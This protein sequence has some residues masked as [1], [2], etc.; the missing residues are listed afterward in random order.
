[1]PQTPGVGVAGAG[2]SAAVDSAHTAVDGGS[3]RRDGPWGAVGDVECAA[4]LQA[5]AADVSASAVG[6]GIDTHRSRIVVEF[7]GYRP[8]YLR[9]LPHR[10]HCNAQRGVGL[11]CLL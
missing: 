11:G 9:Q 3:H 2:R 5:L 7:Y 6:W 10:F 4:E 1:M 8:F